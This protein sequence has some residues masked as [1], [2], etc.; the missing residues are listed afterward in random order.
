[1][2]CSMGCLGLAGGRDCGTDEKRTQ[3]VGLPVWLEGK[4]SRS[5]RRLERGTVSRLYMVLQAM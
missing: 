3:G 2:G 1:M 4:V 5:E